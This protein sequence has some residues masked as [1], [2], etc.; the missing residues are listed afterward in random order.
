MKLF[1][2]GK[3]AKDKQVETIIINSL[4]DIM[5]YTIIFVIAF[6]IFRMILISIFNLNS[7]TIINDYK[8]AVEF[9]LNNT[10]YIAILSILINVG[11]LL[12]FMGTI[13][14]SFK[15]CLLNKTTYKP[16]IRFITISILLLTITTGIILINA[17]YDGVLSVGS[18]CKMSDL[19]FYNYA[20][21]VHNRL[22]LGIVINHV[23]WTLVMIVL[24]YYT[25]K[26]LHN[27][28]IIIRET[29]KTNNL[30]S[31]LLKKKKRDDRR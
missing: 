10:I 15:A 13:I 16:Y 27:K 17:S 25:I 19:S 14:S 2:I 1:N 8:T 4:Y 22:Y 24:C 30:F 26:Y 20:L 29:N 28:K 21:D 7:T 5:I 9:T 6:I 18:L 31:R 23:I 3:K 12:I 11:T